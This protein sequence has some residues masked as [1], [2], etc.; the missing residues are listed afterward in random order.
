MDVITDVLKNGPIAA[1]PFWVR[2]ILLS[3]FS[4]IVCTLIVMFIFLLAFESNVSTHF[5]Y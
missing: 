4:S 5:G 2:G 1:F 3:I